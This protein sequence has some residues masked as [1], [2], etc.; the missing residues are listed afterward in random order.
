M[1]GTMNPGVAD[2][3]EGT[4]GE[5]AAQIAIALLTDAAELLLTTAR[6][7]LRYQSDSSREVSS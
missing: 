5:Q 7:L 1:L 4:G 3:S 6:V 2:Y